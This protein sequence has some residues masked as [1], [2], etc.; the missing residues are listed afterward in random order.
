MES[1]P[2]KVRGTVTFPLQP[3]HLYVRLPSLDLPIPALSLW[4]AG[5]YQSLSSRQE[6]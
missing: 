2:S 6:G 1:E 5:K 4:A 3:H